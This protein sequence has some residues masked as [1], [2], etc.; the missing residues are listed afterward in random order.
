MPG[1]VNPVI[2]ESVCQV[3][4][5]VIGNDATI[6]IAGQSGNFEINVMMPVLAYNLLQSC[7]PNSLLFTNGDND[8]FPL[9]FLQEVEGVRRDVRVVNLSLL[10]TGWY[11]K[12]L[13][14]RMRER[15]LHEIQ[16]GRDRFSHPAGD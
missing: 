5:Q 9:W 12:Q 8:T 11:I 10:N 7:G 1:K 14:D 2:P 16:S 6:A 3:A 15:S 13:R 4:A